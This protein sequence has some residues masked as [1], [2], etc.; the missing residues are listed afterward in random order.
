[1][2][3]DVGCPL[4]REDGSII[5]SYTCFCVLAEESLLGPSPTELTMK[6]YC[7]IWDS[8]NLEGQVPVFTSP[9][10][11]VPAQLY[12]QELRFPSHH[13]LQ[14]SGLWW[15][16]SNNPPPYRSEWPNSTTLLALCLLFIY[17]RQT[18]WKTTSTLHF[19]MLF[20]KPYQKWL[21]SQPVRKHCSLA[22]YC[23]NVRHMFGQQQSLHQFP[24]S[25]IQPTCHNTLLYTEYTTVTITTCLEGFIWCSV[26]NLG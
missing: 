24:Y 14:L 17:P 5:Y 26:T 1:M 7:F 22:E 16:Y 9:N 25:G 10:N 12:P 13:L 15:R 23:Y 6:F 2:F 19:C 20:T 18:I 11:R 4:C 3:L 8:P 21:G